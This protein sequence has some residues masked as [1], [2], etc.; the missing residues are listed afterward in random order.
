MNQNRD[1]P[2]PA[3][4]WPAHQR[5]ELSEALSADT[6]LSQQGREES[7][8]CTSLANLVCEP[9]VSAQLGNVL[10]TV[11]VGPSAVWHLSDAVR[12]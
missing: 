5:A 7:G 8:L 9:A 3:A 11:V 12:L 4:A 6:T 10:V 2:C 1:S